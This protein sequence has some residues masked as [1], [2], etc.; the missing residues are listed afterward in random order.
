MGVGRD[1]FKIVTDVA[2][3]EGKRCYLESSKGEPNVKI[4][5]KM[6][7]EVVDKV[8]CADGKDACEVCFFFSM[9]P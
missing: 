6:G 4:Y 8:N 5:E 9:L 7:F 2:D 3:E 1:L